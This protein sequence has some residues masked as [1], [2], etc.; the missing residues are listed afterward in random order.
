MPSKVWLDTDIGSD[1][2]DAVALTLALLSPE[3]EL[4]GIST[5]Y[6]DVSLR[7]R[8]VL[9]LLAL[10]GM[11]EV[12]V[13]SGC[14]RPLL[15]DRPVY[16]AGWEGEG[17]LTAEDQALTPQPGH[18]SDAIIQ[19]VAEN[20][21]EIVLVAIGPLSNV[22]LALMKE[23]TL[24]KKV[25]LLLIMGGV[26][27]CG[28]NGLDLPFA[29]HNIKSDPEAASVVFRCG[30]P[31][32]MVG[33]DVTMRVRITAEGIRRVGDVGDP[34]RLALANQLQRYL[35]AMKRDYTIMHDPL[36]LSYAIKPDWLRLVSCDVLVETRSEIAAGAT[37]VRRNPAS[38]TQV[39]IDV[40]SER[41]E[42]FLLER[43]TSGRQ[44]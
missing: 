4:I 44:K 42:G 2:D 29:E 25:R 34:L 12:A 6:G 26:C 20:E 38:R 19:A 16:W 5:V 40:E 22:G 28:T 39:A 33:L 36:A 13:Y 14:E 27:R 11:E 35:A 8:M 9:K 41:F 10:A 32:V 24:A 31:I 15:S 30:A 7:S 43:L 23:P 1:V 21:G 17:L 18:A 3:I 37:W